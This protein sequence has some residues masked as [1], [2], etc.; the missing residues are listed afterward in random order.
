MAYLVGQLRKDSSKYN[1]TQSRYIKPI[2]GFQITTFESEN[3]FGVGEESFYEDYSIKLAEGITF[4]PNEVYYLRFK[5]LKIPEF[6]YSSDTSY[7]NYMVNY[8]N[9]DI[10]NLT[11]QLRSDLDS[12]NNS[13]VIETCTIPKAD[14]FKQKIN[15]VN[16]KASIY[17]E[18]KGKS[19]YISFTCVFSPD[20]DFNQYNQIVFRIQRI[21][22]D[23]IEMPTVDNTNI[24]G[25][26]WL[27]D[28]DLLSIGESVERQTSDGV[29]TCSLC[30]DLPTIIVGQ[31]LYSIDSTK[32]NEPSSWG[33]LSQLKNIFD[34]SGDN[35][36]RWIKIGYQCRPGSLIVINQE[37]IRV[38]R[39][40]IFEMDNGLPITDFRIANPGG[41]DPKYIDA[42]LLDY[43]YATNS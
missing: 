9:A 41:S 20:K 38:G 2:T 12:N 33:E 7:H 36:N 17:E 6:F 14:L 28:T 21:S 16:Y 39:S 15:N 42:F 37:P 35:V 1:G 3:P 26:S 34:Q 5:V 22:Y 10:L 18:V 40:G 23:A 29:T 43:A 19:P 30:V 31:Q 27:K 4:D 32:Y 24:M 11:L 8:A 25:R 13:Q